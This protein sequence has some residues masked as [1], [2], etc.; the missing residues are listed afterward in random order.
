MLSVTHGVREALYVQEVCVKMDIKLDQ[1]KNMV[2]LVF[3]KD[4]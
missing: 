3:V 4:L 2:S 1:L